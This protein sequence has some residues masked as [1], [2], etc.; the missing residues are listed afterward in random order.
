MIHH[1]LMEACRVH[2]GKNYTDFRLGYW[3]EAECLAFISSRFISCIHYTGWSRRKGKNLRGVSVGH[4][5]GKNVCLI[6]NIY[7]GRDFLIWRALFFPVSFSFLVMGLNEERITSSN[8]GCCCPRQETWK[9]TQTTNATCAHELTKC[10][11]V[12]SGI[13]E[14]F[15][16]SCNKFVIST[17]NWS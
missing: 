2:E 11:E 9:S 7:R 3:M 13:S 6:L 1:R 4:Y 8:F 16:V 17:L 5:E 12:D 14:Y 15:F 10:S